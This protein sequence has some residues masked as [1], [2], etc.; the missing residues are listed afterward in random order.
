MKDVAVRDTR[1]FAL[2]GHAGD[3]KTSLGEALLCTRRRDRGA[4]QRRRRARSRS[5]TCPKRRSGST[6]HARAV[7]GFDWQGKHLTL[8]DTPGDPN[9]QADGQIALQ[10]LDARGAAWS[11]PWTARRSAPSACGAA[12]ATLGPARRSRS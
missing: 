9:F 6:A 2:I 12:R 4:R 5:T 11:R 8:V 1:N 3:G 10:A 7:F